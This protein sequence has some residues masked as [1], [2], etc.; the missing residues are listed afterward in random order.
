MTPLSEKYARQLLGAFAFTLGGRFGITM[1][2]MDEWLAKF[3]AAT[4]DYIEFLVDY[5]RVTPEEGS[6]NED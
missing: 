5:G 2:N 4:D 3:E 6:D 1:E